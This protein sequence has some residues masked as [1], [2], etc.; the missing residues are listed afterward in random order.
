MIYGD[1]AYETLK[2]E[3][4][5]DLIKKISDSKLTYNQLVTALAT[6]LVEYELN[7]KPLP[8][9]EQIN[10][11]NIIYTT[12]AKIEASKRGKEN[13]KKRS[14]NLKDLYEE[15]K[16]NL[17][18]DLKKGIKNSNNHFAKDLMKRFPNQIKSQEA[19]SRKVSAWRKEYE[20]NNM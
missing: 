15:M 9:G 12:M 5:K 17:W 1:R 11:D 6:E 10:K 13:A 18:S 19:L 14:L 2:L 3:L 16:E 8:L 7:L 4:I 20:S